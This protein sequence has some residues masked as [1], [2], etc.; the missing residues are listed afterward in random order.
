[1]FEAQMGE[2]DS[3]NTNG[4]CSFIQE[5]I[6]SLEKICLSNVVIEYMGSSLMVLKL[7]NI[8]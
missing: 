6:F 8:F 4:L 1:M 2:V 5:L 7:L 3:L